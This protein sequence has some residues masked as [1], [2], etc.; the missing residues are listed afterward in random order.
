VRAF[1]VPSRAAQL[2]ELLHLPDTLAPTG[3]T[4]DLRDA[5]AGAGE[6]SAG[7]LSSPGPL[8]QGQE[9][10]LPK[11]SPPNPPT[12]LGQASTTPHLEELGSLLPGLCLPHPGP[13]CSGPTVQPLP[14]VPVQLPSHYVTAVHDHTVS[15]SPTQTHGPHA[16]SC[17]PLSPSS[18][19][20]SKT[21]PH[22]LL[23][24]LL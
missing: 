10:D 21:K 4:A 9:P 13:F 22:Q 7:D 20:A 5:E 2:T 1:I 6:G 18:P 12:I 14:L 17:W 19:S 24:G 8:R 15:A 3:Q 16:T 11:A 23:S